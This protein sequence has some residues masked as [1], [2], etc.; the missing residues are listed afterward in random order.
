MVRRTPAGFDESCQQDSECN[1]EQPFVAQN[2]AVFEI[3]YTGT[4]SSIY[5][6]ANKLN[7]DTIIKH[8]NLDSYQISCR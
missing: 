3:E 8:T 1:L 6:A 2:K 5:A 7:F 4:E